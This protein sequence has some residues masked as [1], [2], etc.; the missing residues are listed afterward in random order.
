MARDRDERK[1]LLAE[2]RQFLGSMWKR[3][4]MAG[5]RAALHGAEA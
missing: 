2:G 5:G 1:R 4:Q 3:R